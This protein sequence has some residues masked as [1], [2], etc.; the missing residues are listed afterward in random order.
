MVHGGCCACVFDSPACIV[1][2]CS[3]SSLRGVGE[4]LNIRRIPGD[5]IGLR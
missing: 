1:S 3:P 2:V 5:V 4:E